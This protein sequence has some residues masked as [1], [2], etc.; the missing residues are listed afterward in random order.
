MKRITIPLSIIVAAGLLALATNK[1][2]VAQ[3]TAQTQQP[4][5]QMQLRIPPSPV[6]GNP[7]AID[8]SKWFAQIQAQAQ[9]AGQTQPQAQPAPTPRSQAVVLEAQEVYSSQ[10]LSCDSWNSAYAGLWVYNSSSSPGA[11]TFPQMAWNYNSSC[12]TVT[13][14]CGG[15]FGPGVYTQCGSETGLPPQP[16]QL[17]DVLA[18]LL[19]N[20]FQIISV[21][22]P[23]GQFGGGPMQFVLVKPHN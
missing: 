22:T 17:A 8:R 20:G 16:M 5:Q 12:F 19:D 13:N 18:Q 7:I 11:P 21:Q 9:A 1:R 4:S 10:Q 15:L 14:E 23:S 2:A 6:H 3:A